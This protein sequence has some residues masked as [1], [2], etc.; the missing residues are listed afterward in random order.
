M[1]KEDVL[2][3]ITTE[4]TKQL[5][6]IN[7]RLEKLETVLDVYNGDFHGKSILV[8]KQLQP[9]KQEFESKI[10]SLEL[11]VKTLMMSTRAKQKK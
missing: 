4:I 10:E 11:K 6:G 2:E 3:L 8:D 7:K 1:D 5:N 9:V